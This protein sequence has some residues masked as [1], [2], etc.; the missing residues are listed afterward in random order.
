MEASAGLAPPSAPRDV[1][2]THPLT[3]HPHP[4][5]RASSRWT[6]RGQGR[7]GASQDMSIT[8]FVCKPH[9]AADRPRGREPGESSFDRAV[10]NQQRPPDEPPAD[11]ASRIEAP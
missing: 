7:S 1:I 9:Q 5:G 4:A 2:G 3:P 10:A 11:A 8:V 6:P